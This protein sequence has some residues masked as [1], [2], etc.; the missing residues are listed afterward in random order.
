[1]LTDGING[2][3]QG[4]NRYFVGISDFL[5][6]PNIQQMRIPKIPNNQQKIP[7]FIC[8]KNKESMLKQSYGQ[9]VDTLSNIFSI[10][11]DLLMFLDFAQTSE[12]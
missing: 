3:M 10:H 5:G 11:S 7:N 2:V 9:M 4:G 6:I 1:M 12:I 8:Q